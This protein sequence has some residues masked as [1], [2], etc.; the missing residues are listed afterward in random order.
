MSNLPAAMS[1]RRFWQS[2]H[3]YGS[4]L[5]PREL[6]SRGGTFCKARLVLPVELVRL[7]GGVRAGDGLVFFCL[8]DDLGLCGWVEVLFKGELFCLESDFRFCDLLGPLALAD[9][10]WFAD[11]LEL[12]LSNC[13]GLVITWGSFSGVTWFSPDGWFGV[14]VCC[15]VREKQDYQ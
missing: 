10:L 9:G 14:W 6:F 13:R 7:R 4:T 5:R 8:G 11:C 15:N 3:L 2:R 12:M 1:C